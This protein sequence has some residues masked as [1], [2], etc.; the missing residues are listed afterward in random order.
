MAF[1]PGTR[2][3]NLKQYLERRHRATGP[4]V[5]SGDGRPLSKRRKT[6]LLV[7][8]SALISLESWV[9][10]LIVPWIKR[11]GVWQGT[12]HG[13][14][15]GAAVGLLISIAGVTVVIAAA[16]QLFTEVDSRG[17]H[18]PDWAGGDFIPWTSVTEVSTGI[19]PEVLRLRAG[20]KKITLSLMLFCSPAALVS[21]IRRSVPADRLKGF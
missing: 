15:T 2:G 18:W 10:T 11:A 1:I 6:T 14:L 7:M 4:E 16:V 9:W 5:V 17:I 12:S 21:L 3:D 20:K 19:S 8:V 13:V